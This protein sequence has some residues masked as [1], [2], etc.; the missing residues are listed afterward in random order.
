MNGTSFDRTAKIG[1]P[2]QKNI[3]PEDSEAVNADSNN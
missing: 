2:K 1:T 3:I